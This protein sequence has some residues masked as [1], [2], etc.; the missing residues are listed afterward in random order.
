MSRFPIRA[1]HLIRRFVRGWLLALLPLLAL[2]SQA[3]AAKIGTVTYTAPTG[4]AVKAQPEMVTFTAPGGAGQ[5]LMLLIPDQKVSG[6][7]EAWF[8]TVVQQLSS[9]GQITDQSEIQAGSGA[10]ASLLSAAVTVRLSQG[11]QYRFYTARLT[12]SGSASVYVLVTSSLNAVD[13]LQD[14]YV[15]LIR[16]AAPAQASGTAG[17]ST[18]SKGTAATSPLG[19]AKTALPAVKPMNA[20]QFIAAGGNPEVAVIPDEFRCYQEKRGSSVTPELAVQILSGGKYRTAYGSGTYT[21]RKDSSLIKTD[22]T[23]GPLDGAYGYLNIDDYGQTLSISNVGENVLDDSIDFECYQRGARE[24]RQLLDFRLKTPVPAAYPCTAT[25]GSGKSGGT[26]EIL[27]DGMYRLGGQ[28]GRYAADFRSDQND[29]WSDVTFTGGPLDDAN[30]TYQEDEA[31]VRTLSVYR[32][33]ME[34]RLVVKPTPI[35]RYGSTKA[36]TPPKGSGGLSGAYAAWYPDPLAASG[37][38]TCSGLCWDVY[39][40]DRSG[41][42]YTQE[43]DG[44]IDEASCTRTH[45]NGLP[46]CEVYR[47]QGSQIVIGKDKAVPLVRVGTGLKIDGR[48]YEPLLKLDGAKL[49]GSYESKSFVGGGTSTVSGGFQTTLN[50]LPQGRFTRARSGGVSATTTDTG[51]NLG[52]VTGGVTVTSDRRSSG[53]YKVSGYTLALTYGDGHTETLFAYA[54]P[55]K[56][57]RPDLELL[58]LGGSTYTRQDGK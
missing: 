40:F 13:G 7:P 56:N 24:N 49:A 8:R 10:G 11:T 44:S 27:K 2:Q 36:P 17:T 14:T 47:V 42:V 5:G 45:P 48:T 12:G 51:T 52:N 58:R 37:Y 28:T 29:A 31:G 23:G 16:S 4:W 35:P 21:V 55:D 41:Y 39:V 3:M 22:W 15:A 38:G 34:C 30:G 18:P 26:L 6:D 46:V 54:L 1:A 33:K 32:P 25:D 20:A 43:P 57:G 53:T 9:D 19:G 50:F